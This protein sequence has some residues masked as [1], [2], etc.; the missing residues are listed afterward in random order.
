MTT[1]P[2]DSTITAPQDGHLVAEDVAA[3]RSSQSM[4]L[5]WVLLAFAVCWI[6]IT[7]WRREVIDAPPYL[8]QA[9]GLWREADFLAESRFDYYQ[10]AYHEPQVREGGPLCYLI[11]IVPTLI[12]AGMT[13]SKSSQATLIGYHLVCFGCAAIVA[14]VM[15]LTLRRRLD[16]WTSMLLAAAVLTTPLFAVQIDMA[17]LE[18]PLAALFVVTVWLVARHRFKAAAIVSLAAFFIKATGLLLTVALVGYLVMSLVANLVRKDTSSS[19]SIRHG[20]LWTALALVVELAALE[21]RGTYR[22]ILDGQDMPEVFLFLHTVSRTPDVVL[23]ACIALIAAVGTM[24]ASILGGMRRASNGTKGQRIA[25]AVSAFVIEQPIV[26]FSAIVVIGL[27]ISA[28]SVFALPR[29]LAPGIP[30]LYL[31]IGAGFANWSVP[32]YAS[33]TLMALVVAANVAN[34]DG[35]FYRSLETIH[36]ESFTRSPDPHGRSFSLLERSQEYLYD[37]RAVRAAIGRIAN[38]NPRST[39]FADYS[40]VNPLSYPRLGYVDHPLNVVNAASYERALPAFCDIVRRRRDD[41]EVPAPIFV[42][43]GAARLC[44]PPPEA[45]DQRLFEHGERTPLI[46]Y[47]KQLPTFA[48]DAECRTWYFNHTW[49]GAWPALRAVHRVPMLVT[50]GELSR[51]V[52]EVAEARV[53]QPE[54]ADLAD[55]A[56]ILQVAV[57]RE[58]AIVARFPHLSAR[59]PDLAAALTGFVLGWPQNEDGLQVDTVSQW[60]D[61]AA[62]LRATDTKTAIRLLQAAS[63]NPP[64]MNDARLV[65]G[66]VLLASGQTDQAIEAF[67]SVRD[68][69]RE[70][71]D[72]YHGLAMAYRVAGRDADAQQALEE[73]LALL[74]DYAVLHYDLGLLHAQAKRWNESLKCFATASRLR[75]NWQE[76]KRHLQ[77]AQRRLSIDGPET[78]VPP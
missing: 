35:R 51:A 55:L 61:I 57:T 68:T 53:L 73:G 9:L 6:A 27:A 10:L 75:P 64:V 77:Q 71:P 45:G 62:A 78:T 52:R 56:R 66:H 15:L 49:P 5:G 8:D 22:V 12:A 17:G 3:R 54:S 14:I 65:L 60:A 23:L 67:A 2:S 24:C 28:T 38:E 18:V 46:V 7:I 20:L 37:Y 33:I 76:A 69:M 70:Y 32:R 40:F 16:P 39:V 26:L 21:W 25:R 34:L 31:I 1:P 11:S 48:N 58:D 4:R 36:A 74:P 13:I 59:A 41:P 47:R 19:Q 44:I 72:A 50:M 43:V 42:W 29:Y 30:L 63:R